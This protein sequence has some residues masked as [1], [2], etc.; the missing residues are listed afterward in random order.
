MPERP[1]AFQLPHPDRAEPSRNRR[2]TPHGLR[3]LALTLGL[4]LLGGCGDS[5]AG[6]GLSELESR[7]AIDRLVTLFRPVDPIATSDV[8]DRNFRER[9]AHLE[10]LRAAGVTAGRE[11]LARFE[12]AQGECFDVRWALLEAAAYN[13]P[14]DTQPTLERLILVY[15]GKGEEIRTQAV[16]IASATIPQRA[17]ELF[18]PMLREPIAR[19]TRP[20]QEELVRG[21]HTAAR[22]LGLVEARVLCD[23]VVDLRQ[24]PDARYAAVNA[25]ADIGGERAIRA[26]REVLVESASDGNIRRK[27]AQALQRIMPRDAFCT[28]MREASEHEVDELFLFFLADMLDKN[29]SVR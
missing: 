13:A 1:A 11:A 29:C 12:R 24:P 10:G 9:S 6:S 15:D 25:L 20:P 16:R 4:M 5:V 21:W 18:E 3:S 8:H 27:A 17:I 23:L 14:A 19:Q 28:L 26:L 7:A 22:E 2:A